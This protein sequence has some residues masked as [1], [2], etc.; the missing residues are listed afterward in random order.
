[1]KIS[2]L[3]YLVDKKKTR[4][5]LCQEMGSDPP[6]GRQLGGLCSTSVGLLLSVYSPVREVEYLPGVQVERNRL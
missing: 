5:L 3:F 6:V 2:T 4:K 1:M